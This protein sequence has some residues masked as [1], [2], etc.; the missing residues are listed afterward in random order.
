MTLEE[1]EALVL[2]E[3]LLGVAIDIVGAAKIDIA[4]DGPRAPKIVALT[5]LS[6]TITNF[7]GA[8]ILARDGAV[9]E[10][11]A[12]TRMCYENLFWAGAINAR[13]AAFVA[14]MQ[15][16]E[17]A[18]RKSLGEL[19][20]KFSSPEFKG[21]EAARSVRDQ[22]RRLNARF[23]KPSKFKA[24]EVAAMSAVKFAY[25]PYF[26][27]SLDAVHPSLA[28]LGRHLHSEQEA[29][30]KYLTVRVVPPPKAGELLETID[31]ACDALLGVCV[32]VN[33]LL[34]GTAKND[35]LRAVFEKLQNRPLRSPT[36]AT[37]M[38]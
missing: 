18:N 7:R 34:G 14:E 24:T 36:R 10:A 13:G 37:S 2:C 29:D 3:E 22:I 21:S 17:A 5:L 27:L 25:L 30:G 6:P 15:S 16:D 9:V 38:P 31:W 4:A 19:A 12:L 20:L 1:K 26:Q 11:R 32:A 28:A 8:M 35:A 23:A 33:E